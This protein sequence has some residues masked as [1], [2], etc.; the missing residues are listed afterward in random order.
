MKKLQLKIGITVLICVMVLMV[1]VGFGTVR[2]EPA[3]IFAI[4]GHKLFALELPSEISDNIASIFWTMR[5]PRAIAAFLVG[6]A[7]AVT[8]TVMQS[9]LRNPLASSY[10]LGVS[11]GASL[12]VALMVV[13]GISL[14][15]IGNFSLPMIGFVF[16]LGTVLLAMAMA[17]Q[18]DKNLENQTIILIGMVLSL[19]VSSMLT[20]LIVL[21]KEHMEQI[22][23]WQMGSFSAIKW[24]HVQVLLMIII[25]G[26]LFLM[27]FAQEMDIMT[28]GEEQAISVGIDMRRM[29]I[30]LITASALLTGTAVAFVGIIG[31]IDL[32][33]PHVVRKIYGASHRIVVPMSALFGGAFMT[34]ADMVSRTIISPSELPIGAVTTLIGAPFFAYVYFSKRG[35]KRHA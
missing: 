12:G 14:P 6:A 3:N 9:V 33:A 15:F 28:F 18:L 31:F 32:I 20:I 8:G 5:L 26:I 23:F 1:A 27:Y 10:T 16:G 13:F 2:I 24:S 21:S 7:L 11:S 25:P 22:I 30:I 4:F 17:M 19:F 35:V 29:K 34:L